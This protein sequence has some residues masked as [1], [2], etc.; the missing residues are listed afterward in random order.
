MRAQSARLCRRS[1]G[2]HSAS[3]STA[4]RVRRRATTPPTPA[5]GNSIVAT[6]APECTENP[7]PR[8][9]A[10]PVARPPLAAGRATAGAAWVGTA[11][12]VMLTTLGAPPPP[13]E[14]PI[15]RRLCSTHM[16]VELRHLRCF[17]AI[18]KEGNLTRAAARL[19]LTQPALSRTLQQLE[20]SLGLRLVDRS[21]HHLALTA[22]GQAF[23]DK[24]AR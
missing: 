1:R 3:R 6:A 8:T 4:A 19:H 16:I 20:A 24:A 18:A 12:S 10:I 21:T 17:L 22:A 9:S 14:M 11:A 2:R 23:R 15:R 13:R 7:L 5:R